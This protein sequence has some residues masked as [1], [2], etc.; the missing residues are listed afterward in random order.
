MDNDNDDRRVYVT[1]NEA[2]CLLHVNV[3][4]VDRYGA[5][6]KLPR[7]VHVDRVVYLREDV[8]RLNRLLPYSEWM[9]G[10][11]VTA[12]CYA[13]AVAVFLLALPV[14]AHAAHALVQVLSHLL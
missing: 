6:G 12:K 9:S 4:T 14:L 7:Y 2:A 10:K 11:N 13:V 5:S 3:R 1:R 8:E